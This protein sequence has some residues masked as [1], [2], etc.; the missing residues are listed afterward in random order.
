M[1]CPSTVIDTNDFELTQPHEEPWDRRFAEV[2]AEAIVKGLE[3]LL[4]SKNTRS[5]PSVYKGSEDGLVDGWIS[6]MRH[7][8]ATS[9]GMASPFDQAWRIIEYLESESRDFIINKSESERDT[10][11][12]VFSLLSRRFGTGSNRTHIRQ[13]FALR[14]QNE[15]EDEMQFLDALES[16]R[17]QGFPQDSVVSRRYEILQR[18]IEGVRDGELR[19]NLATMY[20]HE[21]Y[22]NEPP[23]VEALRYATEQYMRTRGPP[24]ESPP[25]QTSDMQPLQSNIPQPEML[26]PAATNP[27][28]SPRVPVDQPNASQQSEPTRPPTVSP[29]PTNVQPCFICQQVGHFARDCPNRRQASAPNPQPQPPQVN[30]VATSATKEDCPSDEEELLFCFNSAQSGHEASVCPLATGIR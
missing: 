9:Y 26:S 19:R 10:P 22:L 25:N 8:L 24:R 6:M 21:H 12:K 7:Y 1:C 16:L 14:T 11:E 5:R 23:T 2:I 20:A 4:S 15:G 3:P 18:F 28:G 17:T 30:Q 27:S 29:P 13:S